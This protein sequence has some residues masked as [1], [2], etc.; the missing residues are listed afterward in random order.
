MAK[1]NTFYKAW[2]WCE[3]F[4]SWHEIFNSRHEILKLPAET[5]KIFH[6]HGKILKPPLRAEGHILKNFDEKK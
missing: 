3:I 5:V 4:N 2:S 6:V 1:L